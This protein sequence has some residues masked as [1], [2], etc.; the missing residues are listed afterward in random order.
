MEER[1]KKLM[2]SLPEGMDG[3]LLLAP[4]HR[5]YYLG[6]VSSAGTLLVTRHKSYFIVDFRYIEMARERISGAEVILQD[7]LEEQLR[8]LIADLGLRRIGTDV[9][10]ITLQ[11]FREYQRII[12]SSLI[13]DISLEEA[14]NMQRRIKTAEEIVKAKKAKEILDRVYDRI[15]PYIRPGIRDDELQRR[16]GIL[17]SEEGSQRGSF[18]FWISFGNN[19]ME[20]D[21]LPDH[22]LSGKCLKEG[23]MLSL[24]LASLYEGY[25]ADMSRTVCTGSASAQQKHLY[26]QAFG[27]Q[28]SIINYLKPGAKLSDIAEAAE[29]EA[30]GEGILLSDVFGHGIGMETEE[31]IRLKK[32]TAETVDSGLLLCVGCRIGIPGK[33]SVNIK[34]M[35][36][37]DDDGAYLLGKGCGSLLKEV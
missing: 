11:C 15:I 1:L 27:V 24:R 7:N 21:S 31:G 25:W 14:I 37:V 17:A 32:G 16:L 6:I 26:E 13:S 9:C 10:H 18:G 4:V 20:S 2:E 30:V 5:R 22:I 29:E 35:V 19:F 34:D 23:D 28:E 8:C 3:A 33:E 36:I 12:G